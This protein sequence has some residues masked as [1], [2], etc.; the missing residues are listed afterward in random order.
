MP[1]PFFPAIGIAVAILV[2]GGALLRGTPTRADG[3]GY[4]GL[5]PQELCGLCHS[6]DGISATSKFPKLAGENAAYIEKQLRDFRAGKRGNDGGQMSAIVTEITEAQIPIVAKYFSALPPPPADQELRKETP[7]EVLK[8]A[9]A[10]YQAGDAKRGIPACEQCHEKNNS[11]AAHAPHLT[12]QHAAYLEKQLGDFRS[13]AR[14]NDTT[15]TM[16]AVAQKLTPQEVRELAT[17]LATRS[18]SGG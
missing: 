10:L 3:Q 9:Q 4:D 15:S 2:I 7:P 11:T 16:S 18:R 8:R 5:P 17:F 1:R 12:S 14:T 6:L 13:G